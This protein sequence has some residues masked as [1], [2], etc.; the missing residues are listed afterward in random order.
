MSD[1]DVAMKVLFEN[2]QAVADVFNLCVC[3]GKKRIKASM[4]CPAS[5]NEVELF[6]RTNPG[7]HSKE[8]IKDAVRRIQW[9]PDQ[10]DDYL[11]LGLENQMQ[12]HYLMPWRIHESYHLSYGRQIRIIKREFVNNHHGCTPAEFL[13]K[14]FKGTKLIRCLTIVIYWG[15]EPWDAPRQ[16]TEML[17]PPPFAD[18]EK[19]DPVWTYPLLIPTEIPWEIIDDTEQILKIALKYMW[20]LQSKKNLLAFMEGQTGYK[21]V[22]TSLAKGLLEIVGAK[23]LIDEKQETVNM[24]NVLQELRLEGVRD[25]EERGKIEGK[26]EGKLEEREENARKVAAFYQAQSMPVQEVRSILKQ[27]LQLDAELIDKVCPVS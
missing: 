21:K 17:R 2:D 9:N 8:L 5:N 11:L 27:M 26:L 20:A 7:Q 18:V 4:V 15:T 14:C 10:P 19:F 25:G 22:P 13:S 12:P 3:N 1:F 23:C 24:C 6:C 16:F